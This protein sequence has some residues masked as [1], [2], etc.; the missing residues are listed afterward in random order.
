MD[1][2]PGLFEA[3]HGCLFEGWGCPFDGFEQAF[4]FEMS[5]D[6]SGFEVIDQIVQAGRV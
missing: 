5:Y 2:G 1:S 6:R 3:A 4:E